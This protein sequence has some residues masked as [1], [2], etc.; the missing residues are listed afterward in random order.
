MKKRDLERRMRGLAKEYGV[1][2]TVK[3]GGNHEKWIAGSE[4]IPIPRH[5]EVRENTA[6][7]ILRDW[8]QILVEIAEEQG[9]GK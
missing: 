8:E 3:Q 6:K 2:V 5:N 7:G 4:A 9:E 1:E